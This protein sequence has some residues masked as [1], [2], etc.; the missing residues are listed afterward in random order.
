M[1]FRS[2]VSLPITQTWFRLTLVSGF[3]Y[4]KLSEN[5]NFSSYR[6]NKNP[7]FFP[8]AYPLFLCYFLPSERLYT[9]FWLFLAQQGE[10]YFTALCGSMGRRCRMV[11]GKL[12]FF[13]PGRIRSVYLLPRTTQFTHHRIPERGFRPWGTVTIEILEVYP[14]LDRLAGKVA[15]SPLSGNRAPVFSH[16]NTESWIQQAGVFGRYLFKL[17]DISRFYF[18]SPNPMR[19]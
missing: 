15:S 10:Y 19:V 5:F 7:D 14:A 16:T 3:L 8:Y 9:Y 11:S 12:Y 6:S 18:V 2:D 4:Q 17:T 13:T 1:S